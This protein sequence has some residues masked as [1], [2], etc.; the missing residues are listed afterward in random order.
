MKGAPDEGAWLTHTAH[1][2]RGQANWVSPRL[3]VTAAPMIVAVIRNHTSRAY[4]RQTRWYVRPRFWRELWT[5]RRD[6]ARCGPVAPPDGLY[7]VSVGYE[8][9]TGGSEK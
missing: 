4:R 6:R 9:E 2:D 1:Q 7:L 8:A 3:S 5:A